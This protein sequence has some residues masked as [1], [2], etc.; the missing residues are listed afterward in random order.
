[1]IVTLSVDSRADNATVLA[2]YV[3]VFAQTSI[4]KTPITII[5]TKPINVNR[6]ILFAFILAPG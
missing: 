3:P 1:V 5:E 4:P 2:G 6:M